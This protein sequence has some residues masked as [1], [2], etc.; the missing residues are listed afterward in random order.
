MCRC[1]SKIIYCVN[2]RLASAILE[3]AA[4]KLNN[5]RG[6]LTTVVKNKQINITESGF[7]ERTYTSPKKTNRPIVIEAAPIDNKGPVILASANWGKY[8]S[9]AEI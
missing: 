3:L 8:T 9:I 2:V 4:A 6:R 5:A 1:T 7:V